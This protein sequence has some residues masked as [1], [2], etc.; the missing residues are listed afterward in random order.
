MPELATRPALSHVG[1]LERLIRKLDRCWRDAPPAS[2]RPERGVGRREGARA[3]IVT[4]RRRYMCT[5]AITTISQN[6]VQ[7]FVV[8]RCMDVN[9]SVIRRSSDFTSL[10]VPGKPPVSGLDSEVAASSDAIIGIT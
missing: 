3:D 6:V 5:T 8:W 1:A 4:R 10:V 9:S 2:V 7:R